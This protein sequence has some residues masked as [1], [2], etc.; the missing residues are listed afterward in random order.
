MKL[1]LTALTPVHIGTGNKLEPFDY[2]IYN[3]RVLVLNHEACLEALFD[4]DPTYVDKY[5]EWVE[6]TTKKIDNA[7]A[8]VKRAK[9]KRDRKLIADKNQILSH[10]RRNFNIIDFAENVLGNKELANRLKTET[11]YHWY[12]GYILGKPRNVVQ[13]AEIIKINGVPYIPGSSIKGAIRTALAFTVISQLD[14]NGV[15]Q[16]LAQQ[17]RQSPG[18]R[19]ML[20][21]IIEKSN[22]VKEIAASNNEQQKRRAFGE[23]DHL[24][25]NYEK[26]I[27]EE[28]E[29]F[30]YGCAEDEK[31]LAK[32][33]DPKFDIMRL[34][35]VSDTKN[36]KVDILF[37][38][39]KAFKYDRMRKQIGSQPISVAEF[40]DVDSEFEFSI[41]VDTF[42]IKRLFT[43]QAKKGW[44][45]FETKFSR[46]FNIT[47]EDILSLSHSEIEERIVKRIL[48]SLKLFSSAI[49]KKEE[50]WLEQFSSKETYQLLEALKKIK[51]EKAST[52]LGFASGWFATTV[53]LAFAKNP[54]LQSL[55]PD[56]IYAFNL[57]LIQKQE[58]L[59]R[60]PSNRRGD[61]E[62]QIKLLSRTPDAKNYPK[63]RRLIADRYLPEDFIGW[64]EIGKGEITQKKKI[65]KSES[66]KEVVTEDDNF[67]DALAKLIAKF[68]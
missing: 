30:V 21:E 36:S 48:E 51:P 7:E 26:K 67:E 31:P 29:K 61:V 34:I 17:D 8:E 38:E 50:Q 4:S 11:N 13:L 27:G 23:L 3:D 47:Q 5:V 42:L 62:K 12:S 59:I 20:T 40:I 60:F 10:I 65:T 18:I 52:K 19:A 55:L 15:T 16:F 39:M 63:S 32:L 49:H 41:E 44:V 6:E 56:I 46:L 14:E 54:N 58:R 33:N 45:D 22:G 28:V 68:N 24:R 37:G 53:G 2:Y 43:G 9:N 57:D 66:R 1:K 35:R 25:R 64:V